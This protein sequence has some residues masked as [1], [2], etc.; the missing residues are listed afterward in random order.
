M[1]FLW[2]ESKFYVVRI[3]IGV[4]ISPS[5][6][7]M[8][9]L[10]S[11]IFSLSSKFVLLFSHHIPIYIY[12]NKYIYIYIIVQIL[13]SRYLFII[14]FQDYSVSSIRMRNSAG[15]KRTEHT[16]VRAENKEKVKKRK[17]TDGSICTFLPCLRYDSHLLIALFFPSQDSPFLRATQTP[18][19]KLLKKVENA[20]TG[21]VLSIPKHHKKASSSIA[22]FSLQVYA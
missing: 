17:I 9:F 16:L 20:N 4:V 13:C 6:F 11:S 2:N 8:I 5:D 14:L 7:L 1:F 15:A 12:I 21:S 18:V 10:C 3:F 19:S 22:E